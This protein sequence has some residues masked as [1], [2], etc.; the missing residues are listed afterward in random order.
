MHLGSADPTE[1]V[2][3]MIAAATAPSVYLAEKQDKQKYK[4]YKFKDGTAIDPP[5]KFIKR[6]DSTGE[7][8][9]SLLIIG[10]KLGRPLV[11]TTCENELGTGSG[12]TITVDTIVFKLYY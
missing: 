11:S 8:S 1:V 5:R 9:T 7:S 10:E 6:T 4:Q 3:R 12:Q 2:E